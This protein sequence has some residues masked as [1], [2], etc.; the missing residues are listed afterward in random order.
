MAS[1]R[2]ALTAGGYPGGAIMMKRFATLACVL[3]LAACNQTPAAPDQSQAVPGAE[4]AAGEGTEEIDPTSAEG[5]AR[6]REIVGG[7]LDMAQQQVA[8][9]AQRDAGF[10]DENALIPLSGSPHN[11]S[12][13]LNAGVNYIFLGACDDDCTNLDI[14]LIDAANAV[15]ASDTAPDDFPIVR[16]RPSANG[17]YTV[18]TH[19]RT[20]AVEPCQLGVRVLT[21]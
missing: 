6:L 12:V 20:C 7:Y 9:N 16:F 18:R 17:T 19:L 4:Q 11:W 1:G 21:E 14:E 2:L 15:V 3:A 8:P 13:N 5:Q 10:E